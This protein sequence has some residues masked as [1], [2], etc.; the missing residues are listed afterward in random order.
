MV[1]MFRDAGKCS[2]HEWIEI[3]IVSIRHIWFQASFEVMPRRGEHRRREGVLCMHAAPHLVW[4][5]AWAAPPRS[6][7]HISL[8]P[9]LVQFGEIKKILMKLGKGKRKTG[10]RS[11][12][13][14]RLLVGLGVQP[15]LDK[16]KVWLPSRAGAPRGKCC[17][18]V[19]AGVTMG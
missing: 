2:R 3:M 12:S 7:H 13:R 8:L 11:S 16:G 19:T 18:F 9:F 17:G 4:P 1:S 6:A 10:K 15:E 14:E 5:T